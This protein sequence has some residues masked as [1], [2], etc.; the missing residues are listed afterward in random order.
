MLRCVS[1]EELDRL[2][3]GGD[4]ELVAERRDTKPELATH[5]LLLVLRC[6]TAHQEP[7]NGL[8][9][10]IVADG[11]LAELQG[12]GKLAELEVDL[13][14]ILQRAPIQVLQALLFRKVPLAHAVIFEQR[15]AVEP[16]RRTIGGDNLPGPVGPVRAPCVVDGGQELSPVDPPGQIRVEAI[17]AVTVQDGPNAMAPGLLT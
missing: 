8:E 10:R 6:I 11:K 17:A 12:L 16:D 7:V 9:T 14:R 2:A 4:T 3:G 15:P 5:E 13:R 1:P